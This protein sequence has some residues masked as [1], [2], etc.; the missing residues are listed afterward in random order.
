[1]PFSGI[2]Q[3]SAGAA[4]L[5]QSAVKDDFVLIFERSDQFGRLDVEFATGDPDG[6]FY[7]AAD[8]V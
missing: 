3:R 5:A 7:V 4:L 2:S 8:V 6:G 1:M